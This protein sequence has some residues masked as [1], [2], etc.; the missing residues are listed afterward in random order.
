MLI[1]YKNIL[2]LYHN[3]LLHDLVLA[4]HLVIFLGWIVR[5]DDSMTFLPIVFS[6][7]PSTSRGVL[8]VNLSGRSYLVGHIRLRMGANPQT[9]EN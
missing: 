4:V 8:V 3:G 2:L 5:G 7:L 6:L 9:G 1:K